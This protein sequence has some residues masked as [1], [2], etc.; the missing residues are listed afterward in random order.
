V[1]VSEVWG[2]P[3]WRGGHLNATSKAF[4]PRT[5]DG[6]T[7]GLLA[8]KRKPPLHSRLCFALSGRVSFSN[9]P[10]RIQKDFCPRWHPPAAGPLCYSPGPDGSELPSF[11]FS[12]SGRLQFASSTN[13]SWKT[14]SSG[15]ASKAPASHRAV[16]RPGRGKLRWSEVKS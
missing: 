2:F 7:P 11:A 6:S 9:R 1:P 8:L 10:K 16:P 3:L 5:H 12:L 15:C 13:P 4:R 14:A